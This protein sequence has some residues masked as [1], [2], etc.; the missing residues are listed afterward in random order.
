MNENIDVSIIVP[1]YNQAQYL[2]EA[3]QSVLQ[4]SIENWECVIVND[5]SNDNTEEVA[6]KWLLRDSRFKYIKSENGGLSAARNSGIE[7]AKGNFIL[8]LDADDIIGET[9]LELALKQFELNTNLKIV[10]CKAE[11]FGIEN[12]EWKL[13]NFTL[14]NLAHENM[15]F[16]SALFKRK[17]WKKVKGYDINMI[18]GWE[19]WEFWI[20]ILKNGGE[21][22]CIESVNFYYRIKTTSMTKELNEEKLNY[23]KKYLSIKHAD[24]FVKQLGSFFDIN[25]KITKITLHNEVLVKLK[26]K[27]F[28]LNQ[29]CY[30]IFGFVIFKNQKFR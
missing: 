11:K 17:D 16:C 13:N 24:F 5:G 14:Y 23:L 18:Y 20:A 6:N 27:K 12:G 30:Q 28:L 2:E 10:Y 7:L 25:N 3:L 29:L 8:P 19:D 15:I 21:V 9:Y 1:C 4:Q 22:K 26:S